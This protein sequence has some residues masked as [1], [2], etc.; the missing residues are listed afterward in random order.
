[1]AGR[2]YDG[3]TYHLVDPKTDEII[4]VVTKTVE[5]Y[6]ETAEESCEWLIRK[7]KKTLRCIRK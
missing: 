2:L 6:A 5:Y 3:T 4:E 1:M 7:A